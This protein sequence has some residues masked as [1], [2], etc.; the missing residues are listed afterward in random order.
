MRYNNNMKIIKFLVILVG[1]LFMA[2]CHDDESFSNSTQH[3]LTF[4]VDTVKMDT[5]FSNVP[6]STKSF[7]VYNRSGKGI[8]LASV[9]LKAGNQAGFRVNVDGTYLG[10]NMGYQT[11]GLE[12]RNKDS[13]RVFVEVTTTPNRSE[14]ITLVEDKLVFKLESGAEQ[15]VL[16]HAHTWDAISLTNLRVKN[17]TTIAASKPI[18]VYGGIKVDSMATLRIAAGTQLYFHANAGVDVYGRLLIEGTKEKEVL[19]RGDRLDRMFDYLPYN[20]VSGQWQGLHFH[21]SSYDNKIEYADINNTFD[22]IVADS[23]AVAQLKLHLEQSTIHNCQGYGLIANN[24][25][26]LL[27]NVQITNTLN[28]CLQVN[29]GKVVINNSTLAQ[30]YPFDGRRGAALRLSDANYAFESFS[31]SNTLIT[32]YASD[33]VMITYRDAA[34][35]FSYEFTNCVLRTPKITTPDSVRFVRVVYENVGDTVAYGKG[36]FER[37]DTEN[38][39]YSFRL[40]KSSG[41][42]DKADAA[43]ATTN[44]RK[45][46]AR[47][48]LPDVGAYEYKED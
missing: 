2:S 38:L 47:D 27:S 30:F 32:G 1:V 36:H 17:D 14:D 22:G 43:T 42:V 7:W 31:C 41:A 16:L 21:S 46:V 40:R 37:I 44:D 15:E 4:S 12:I 29:G 5:V 25:Y 28:D 48:K 18:I 24:S 45:G 8:R 39:A 34:T 19:L 6:S 3:R 23:S 13:V 33:E 20:R 10:Q 11:T 26:I 35:P 9:R